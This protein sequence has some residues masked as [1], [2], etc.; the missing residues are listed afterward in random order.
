MASTVAINST[1]ESV[2]GPL[3]KFAEWEFADAACADDVNNPNSG[4]DVDDASSAETNR[5]RF[6]NAINSVRGRARTTGRDATAGEEEDHRELVATS[7]ASS[8]TAKIRNVEMLAL[9]TNDAGLPVRRHFDWTI[10]SV[11]ISPSSSS[12]SSS[13]DDDCNSGLPSSVVIMYGDVVNEA[14]SSDR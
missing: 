5:S 11:A 12:S 14:E 6:R 4:D 7:A 9:G 8:S 2:F 13:K 1:F 10:G 3:Y